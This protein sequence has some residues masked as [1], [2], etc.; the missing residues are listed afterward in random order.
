MHSVYNV[1]LKRPSIQT[2]VTPSNRKRFLV[3]Y[4][5]DSRH[6]L[7]PDEAEPDL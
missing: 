1:R 6:N 3:F 2:Y 7:G 5:L 4:Q